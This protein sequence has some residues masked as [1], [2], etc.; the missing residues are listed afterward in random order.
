MPA[1]TIARLARVV[2]SK[3]A[4]PFELTYDIIFR[5]RTIFNRLKTKGNI[6]RPWVC[7]VLGVKAR[8]IL[9]MVW[10]DP[11]AA[12]KITVVRS[13]ASGAAEDRD[14]YGAQ[15][16]VPLLDAAVTWKE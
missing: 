11:A 2:R 3:N 1:S 13:V 10:F 9:G 7:R 5:S 8:D 14:V 16:H 4:G 6:G 12:L 15:Q